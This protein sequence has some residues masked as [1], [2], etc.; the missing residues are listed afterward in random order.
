M[1][2]DCAGLSAEGEGGAKVSEDELEC[3]KRLARLQIRSE[4]DVVK[5]VPN[6]AVSLVPHWV[7][8]S[9]TL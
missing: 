5:V 8:G 9:P 6:R 7:G 1:Y 4:S 3:A 2:F